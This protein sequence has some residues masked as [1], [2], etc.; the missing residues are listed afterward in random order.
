MVVGEREAGYVW[1][2]CGLTCLF[3]LL[4]NGCIQMS[5]VYVRP[6]CEEEAVPEGLNTAVDSPV[7]GP[8]DSLV[9]E[10]LL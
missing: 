9:P 8:V 4:L 6:V 10:G 7:D 3:Y 1:G 5:A 2:E